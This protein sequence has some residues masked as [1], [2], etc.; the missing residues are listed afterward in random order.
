LL[1]AGSTAC[2]VAAQYTIVP[3]AHTGAI[4]NVPVVPDGLPGA[5]L[6]RPRIVTVI[7]SCGVL[8]ANFFQTS[9][10]TAQLVLVV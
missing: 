2:E 5:A 8:L 3:S 4:S 1:V 9:R 10:G 7:G 6:F